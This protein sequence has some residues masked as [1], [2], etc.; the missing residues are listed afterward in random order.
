MRLRLGAGGGEAEGQGGA[1]RGEGERLRLA[2]ALWEG[3]VRL[4]WVTLGVRT[5]AVGSTSTPPPS[6]R[7]ARP[8]AST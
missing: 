1:G 3:K 7:W 2:L 4:T 8:T 6:R 5:R